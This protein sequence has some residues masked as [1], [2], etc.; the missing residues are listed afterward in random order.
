MK[1]RVIYAF[2]LVGFFLMW[3]VFGFAA[4]MPHRAAGS[5]ATV[6]PVETSI[7]VPEATNSVGIPITG[8]QEPGW[9]EIV[10]FYGLIGLTALFLVFGLL[11]LA[12]KSTAPYTPHE[13]PPTDNQT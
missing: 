8:E 10:V 4:A 2:S 13:S 6:P 1:R 3:G 9:T 7:V 12:N 5:P 11:K